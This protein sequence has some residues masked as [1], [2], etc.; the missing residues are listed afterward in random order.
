MVVTKSQSVHV[1]SASKAV[2]RSFIVGLSRAQ[3]M[4]GL[5]KMFLS[6]ITSKNVI[7]QILHWPQLKVRQ[8]ASSP[9]IL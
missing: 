4:I 8:V 3:T 5:E 6:N 2:H 7:K 1:E 9:A